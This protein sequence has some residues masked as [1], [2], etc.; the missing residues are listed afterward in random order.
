MKRFADWNIWEH[1]EVNIVLT[2]YN[3]IAAIGCQWPACHI[4]D[5]SG[6]GEPL[7]KLQVNISTATDRVSEIFD[8]MLASAAAVMVPLQ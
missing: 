2:C 4:N 8:Q 1:N 6:A 5:I 3:S 7:D